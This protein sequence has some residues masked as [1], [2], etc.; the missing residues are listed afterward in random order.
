M[1]DICIVMDC[2]GHNGRIEAIHHGQQEILRRLSRI[3]ELIINEGEIIVS[4][5]D[6][7]TAQVL[8]EIGDAT[9]AQ[10]A[11]AADVERALADLK[12]SL[13]GTLTADQV[14]HFDAIDAGLAGIKSSA[15]AITAAVDTADP[16]PAPTSEGDSPLR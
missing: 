15:D 9:T 5:I 6:D 11:S 7:R 12:A 13:G 10:A 3:E 8:T 4:E 14:A 16:S 2:P 1:P